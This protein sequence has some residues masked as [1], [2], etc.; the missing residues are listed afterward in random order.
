[1][2]SPRPSWPPA[3]APQSVPPAPESQP[4]TSGGH[5]TTIGTR[6]VVLVAAV[7]AAVFG[8]GLAGV[9]VGTH[10]TSPPRPAVA[11]TAA[12]PTVDP[13]EIRA[14]TVDLCT[15]FA[16]AYAA[17][18]TPQNSAADVVPAANYIADALRENPIADAAVRAAITESLR[19][20]RQHAAALSREPARGAVQ[21]P[22]NWTAAAANA[23]D[24]QV[25]TACQG[26]Q[27]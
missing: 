18:P 2:N 15:R 16:A 3:T 21:P 6:R 11:P 14:E 4:L 12:P 13:D 26:Y 9:V 23:A 27:G 25:W 5:Q 19:L 1:M 24:D 10:V 7:I 8:A 20:F 22:T 17:L